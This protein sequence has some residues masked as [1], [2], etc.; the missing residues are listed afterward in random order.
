MPTLPLYDPTITVPGG[1]RH[2]IAPGGWQHW[3]LDVI[4]DATKSIT[5]ITLHDGRVNDLAYQRRYLRFKLSPTRRDPPQPFQYRAVEIDCY[6]LAG[7][8]EH[9]LINV[10]AADFEARRSE[11]RVRIGEFSLQPSELD[12]FKL[13]GPDVDLILTPGGRDG[14]LWR[15]SGS[16]FGQNIEGGG[17]LHVDFG[18]APKPAGIDYRILFDDRAIVGF[19]AGQKLD[20]TIEVR[21]FRL[22]R[23]RVLTKERYMYDVSNEPTAVAIVDR[24]AF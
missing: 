2:V 3:R 4:D 17:L 6:S 5:V 13:A 23:R 16:V 19:L 11:L 22:Q 1:W 18:D 12:R 9:K 24:A 8:H 21:T 15:I 10:D 7:K 14:T 20:E